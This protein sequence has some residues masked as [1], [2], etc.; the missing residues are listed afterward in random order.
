MQTSL[1]CVRRGFSTARADRAQFAVEVALLVLDVGASARA[2]QV[3]V[4]LPQHGA[5]D[6]YP[7]HIR[8]LLP[9]PASGIFFP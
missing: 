9:A 4:I 2:R 5:P 8:L 1:A 7:S 6:I 3:A